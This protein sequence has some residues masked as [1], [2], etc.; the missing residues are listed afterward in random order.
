M[1]FWLGQCVPAKGNRLPMRSPS[2]WNGS[3]F[4]LCLRPS[5]R[6]S[7]GWG[8]FL[9]WPLHAWAG[10]VGAFRNWLVGRRPQ[11]GSS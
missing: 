8:Y 9:P 10:V 5:H 7:L 6:G 11:M 4:P 1:G 2:D 3:D